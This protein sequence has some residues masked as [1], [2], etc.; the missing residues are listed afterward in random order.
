MAVQAAASAVDIIFRSLKVNSFGRTHD[1]SVGPDDKPY[2][3]SGAAV[4]GRAARA[5][6]HSDDVSALKWHVIGMSE[7]M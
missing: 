4:G 2:C 6:Q 1:G 3:Q 7:G 5:V